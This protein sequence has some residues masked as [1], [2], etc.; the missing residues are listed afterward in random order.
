MLL[1]GPGNDLSKPEQYQKGQPVK[2]FLLLS[3]LLL[4]F[5]G[6]SPTPDR[7]VRAFNACVTRHAQDAV[8]CEAP[9]QA[10]QVDAP[11]LAARLLPEQ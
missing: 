4:L 9:L 8:V 5:S 10:Y 3:F 2:A 6:C 11:T 1:V 7:N